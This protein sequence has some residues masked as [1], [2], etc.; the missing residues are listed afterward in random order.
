MKMKPTL[1]IASALAA[2]ASASALADTITTR[3][4]AIL[5]GRITGIDKGQV[6]I[7]TDYAGT[8]QVKQDKIASMATDAPISVRTADGTLATGP[9]ATDTAGVL[10]V[11]STDATVRTSADKLAA[12]W[13]AGTP[14]PA[15]K[16][17]ERKWKY[18]ASADITGASGNTDTSN[19]G[20][21]FTATLA[22][23][24]DTLKFFGNYSY[25]EQNNVATA[26][27][28]VVGADY[29]AFYSEHWGWYARTQIEKDD[30]QDLD[31]RSTSAAGASYRFLNDPGHTL[32]G[33]AGLS[34]RYDSYSDYS[35]DSIGLDFGL[36]HMWK[37]TSWA[38][39]TNSLT[40]TPSIEDFASY[41][42]HHDSGIEMPLGA[43]DNWKIRVGISH[44]YNSDPAPGRD[45]LDTRYYIKLILD[46]E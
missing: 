17:L 14:D 4:G 22:G 20:L 12:A 11:T 9:L 8:L 2:A 21:G 1:L 29:Q 25:A 40:Y 30:F 19:I 44:E 26:D 23:K 38:C 5:K 32:V 33:R 43:S 10:T 13:P 6:S 37:F 15:V 46:W 3:D 41:I 39:M 42:A 16:A 18:R 7:E 45:S 27:Y 31:L 36:D 34:Y 24:D 35:E 28:S